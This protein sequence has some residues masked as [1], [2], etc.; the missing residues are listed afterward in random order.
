[1]ARAALPPFSPSWPVLKEYDQKHLL[2]LA[3]PLGG[4]G[5]GTVSLGGRGHLRDWEVVNRPNKGYFPNHSFFALW[6]RPAGGE[7]VTRVLEGPIEEAWY[8]GGSG[9]VAQNHGLP[10]FRHCGC[11]A[12][13]PLMQVLLA[14]PDVPLGVRLEAFNPL[15]PGDAEAS[16]LPLAVLRFVLLNRGTKPVE[17]SICGSLQNVIGAGAE[18]SKPQKNVNEFRRHP[19]V[20][21]IFMRSEGVPKHAETFGTVA[22]ATTTPGRVTHRTAWEKVGWSCDLLDF[23]DDFSAEGQVDERERAGADAPYASLA[24]KLKVPAHGEQAVTFLLSWHFPNRQTWTPAKKNGG[25]PAE[26]ENWI[27]NHYATRFHDAWDAVEQAAERLKELERKTVVF[28]GSFCASDLPL[29]IKDAALSN[30][31]TLRTQTAFR[32]ADGRLFGWEGCGDKGGCC[33]GSCTHVWNYEQATAFLFG[34]L[35]WTM[36]ET[37]FL[38][39]T[40]D[41]GHMAFR[42]NLP[43][44]KAR[45]F[46]IA[47]ADG[48]MGCLVK[49]YREWQLSGDD[50]KLRKLW[51]RARKALEFCWIAG[52]WDSDQDGV[53]EGCQHNTMDVEYFGPNPHC[54]VAYLAALRAGEEIARYLGEN[55]FAARCREIFEKGRRKVDAELF[56]GEYYEQRVVPIPD[57]SRIAQGLRLTMGAAN[58]ADPDFQIGAGCELNQL[59]GQF[60]AQVAGLGCLLERRH[61]VTALRSIV[62][63]NFRNLHDLANN[64][65]SYALGDEEG[66]VLCTW[67][68]GKRPRRPFPYAPEVWSSLEYMIAVQLIGEGLRNEARKLVAATRSRFDGAKRNPFNEP[69]CGHHYA[70]PMASWALVTAW[71]GFQYS[72]VTGALRFAPLNGRWF[73]SNGRAW[74]TCR[75]RGSVRSRVLRLDVLHGELSLRRVE[76]TGFGAAELG[77][78]KT[79]TPG[80]PLEV[81]VRRSGK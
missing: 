21:G 52:G 16:G 12:A 13:Y 9:A 71:T 81:R 8:D 72:A 10:R 40:G 7:A 20:F 38:S 43:L 53:M 46:G 64:M 78:G 37:E 66:L 33:H 6:A 47:A 48:Q 61:V 44:A 73:W 80:R 41:R 36:R 23:W 59:F 5:T 77:A 70:R 11:G 79:V 3:L 63:H 75:I 50:E 2:R 74:G 54:S 34:D 58:L 76:L 22:L 25:A 30:V 49:L 69:E 31:S 27:G 26:G 4:I 68:R 15:V 60:L 39:C 45:E 62:K 18:G 19:R 32:A 57:A 35:A 67:P 28:A 56:N 1:M 65:R 42:V 17:A 14:D 51:P 55:D 24:V 29:E